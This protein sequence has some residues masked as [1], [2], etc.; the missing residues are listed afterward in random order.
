MILSTCIL[1]AQG[2]R[3]VLDL[4]PGTSF[5]TQ[6]I[7]SVSFTQEFMGISYKTD[8]RI[9]NLIKTEVIRQS[10]AT[11]F[12][13]RSSYSRMDFSMKS[14]MLDM[15]MSSLSNDSTNP[16][17]VIM[18]SLI[19][20]TFS[21]VISKNGELVKINGLDEVIENQIRLL[22]LPEEEKAEF[23]KNFLESFGEK[24]LREYHIMSCIYYSDKLTNPGDDWYKSFMINPYGIPMHL[25]VNVRLK[26][27]TNNIAVFISEGS[28]AARNMNIPPNTIGNFAS[29]DLSG[30]HTSEVRINLS[31]GLIVSNQTAQFINGR[32]ST[33]DPE[34]AGKTIEIP[35]KIESRTTITLR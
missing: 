20:R 25:L 14:D 34:I 5:Q 28:L 35:M 18:R 3:I 9:N 4:R 33:Y 10:D 1:K 6:V 2:S 26:E 15:E 29:Y 30:T 32:I 17:N 24:S 21:Q 31:T 12:D 7:S 11:S 23:R 22:D 27:I 8:T 13:F 19:G 16:M